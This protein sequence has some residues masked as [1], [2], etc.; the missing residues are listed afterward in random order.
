M[1]SVGPS[2]PAACHCPVPHGASPATRVRGLPRRTRVRESLQHTERLASSGMRPRRGA[3]RHR[4][5]R[6]PGGA[7]RRPDTCRERGRAGGVRK[8][9]WARRGARGGAWL[10]AQPRSPRPTQPRRPVTHLPTGSTCTSQKP[11][12]AARARQVR[13]LAPQKRS[14]AGALR[15]SQPARSRRCEARSQPRRRGPARRGAARRCVLV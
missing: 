11:N 13:A 10:S 1:Q 5:F 14:R 12:L 9:L 7:P 6:G 3:A 2:A 8:A 15:A 4:V